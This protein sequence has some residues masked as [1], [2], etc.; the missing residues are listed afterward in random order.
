MPSTG[1]G[2]DWGPANSQGQEILEDFLSRP[3]GVKVIVIMTVAV[4]DT[5]IVMIEASVAI[6]G[7]FSVTREVSVTEVPGGAQEHE[8]RLGPGFLR[9]ISWLYPGHRKPDMA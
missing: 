3:V 5:V 2:R 8:G 4:V 7:L 9:A 1:P 6:T